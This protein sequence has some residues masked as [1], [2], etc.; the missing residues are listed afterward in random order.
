M[1][2][3]QNLENQGVTFCRLDML[4]YK[5]R[6]FAHNYSQLNP[7]EAVNHQI[8]MKNRDEILNLC[9]RQWIKNCGVSI[10]LRTLYWDIA[11]AIIE[12]CDGLDFADA[13]DKFEER[14]K[15]SVG[16]DGSDVFD[17][18][19]LEPVEKYYKIK[20]L[21]LMQLSEEDQELLNIA[22]EV[23][24]TYCFRSLE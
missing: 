2:N 9:A 4:F 10:G 15:E 17:V 11:I 20:K 13:T 23:I 21:A 12:I 14:M 24:P 3:I 6:T 7:G 16:G 1:V 8:Y 18:A 22:F 5:G 19:S